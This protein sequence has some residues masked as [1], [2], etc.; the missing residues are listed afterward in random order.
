MTVSDDD[1]D[2]DEDKGDDDDGWRS[3]IPKKSHLLL[4]PSWTLPLRFQTHN[5]QH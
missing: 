4:G 1:E 2:G 3:K 5:C